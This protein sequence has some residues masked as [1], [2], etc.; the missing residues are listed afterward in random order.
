MSNQ[1]DEVIDFLENIIPDDIR[2]KIEE[3]VGNF[4]IDVDDGYQ[5]YDDF[6]G[7]VEANIISDDTDKIVGEIDFFIE[8]NSFTLSEFNEMLDVSFDD[9]VKDAK[10][11]DY[12][13][14]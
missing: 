3:K 1:R 2:K 10:V 12:E 4:Y 9:Y 7:T 13:I 11:E 14:Y 6:D 8:Q 5:D